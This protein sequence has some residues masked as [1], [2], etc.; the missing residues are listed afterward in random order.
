D[1]ARWSPPEPDFGFRIVRGASA[2]P[3][4]PRFRFA[5]AWGLAAA[6]VLVLAAAAAI[7]NVE[8]RYGAGGLVVR[9]GWARDPGRNAGASLAMV[10]Q[11]FQGASAADVARHQQ[12]LNYLR[13]VAQQQTR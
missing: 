11:G 9:T 6:A 1:L 2:P 5:P 3:G 12:T 4:R 13:V 7:A 10:Q 8:V